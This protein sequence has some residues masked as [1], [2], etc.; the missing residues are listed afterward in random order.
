MA[1]VLIIADDLTGANACAAGFT[2]AGLRSVTLRADTSP[3]AIAAYQRSYDTLVVT[4]DSRHFAPE[5]AART[6]GDV[7]AAGWPVRLVCSRADSTL[8]GNVGVE[9]EAIIRGVRDRGTRA[10]G[11]CMPAFPG[12]DRQTVDGLQLMRGTRLEHTELA[13]EVRS[14]VTTSSV[15]EVLRKGSRLRTANITLTDVTGP[16]DALVARIRELLGAAGADADHEAADVIVAD[17]LTDKHLDR[18]AEAAVEAA[19][20]V[21]WVGID[22]GPGSLAIARA[23]RLRGRTGAA[24]LLAVAGSATELTQLQL[25]RVIADRTVHL[26]RP[27]FRPG[28]RMP[29]VEA[30]AAEV[31]AALERAGT[32][33]I[34]LLASVVHPSDVLSLGPEEAD[35][36]PAALG[37]ITAAVLE[38]TAVGGLYTTGGDITASVLDAAGGAGIEVEEEVVPLAAA[39]SI[40]GGRFSG[41]P[42]VTKGGLVGDPGTALTCIDHLARLA[43]VRSRIL[44]AP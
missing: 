14:P 3:E 35:E 27:T 40:V 39:G 5:Q 31:V 7:L 12:A 33:E 30:T 20:D 6:V 4:T 25:Q 43:A 15:A 41:L 18:V 21:M 17:A 10:V 26:V 16:F 13:H 8:R 11:L 38:A 19:P 29:A 37:R 36:L 9:A 34:V 42:I 2:R 32:G 22:P 28:S 1:S 24:P 44:A 23:M